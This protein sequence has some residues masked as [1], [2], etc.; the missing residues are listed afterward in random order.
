MKKT[1]VIAEAGINHNG[2]ISLAHH[3]IDVAADAGADV[4]KFQ[5]FRAESLATKNAPKAEYQISATTN[6]ESQYAMLN[7]LELTQ[8]AHE[9]LFEHCKKRGIKFLST[10][11]DLESLD[12]L[13]GFDMPF[14]KIPSGE[15]T[16]LPYLRKV[17]ALGKEIVLSTGMCELSEIQDA[18]H[19]LESA[20]T[21][22]EKVT[23]MHCTTDY[24]TS[25]ADVNL[26]AMLQ[27]Q[28]A[29]RVRVGYSDH[30]LGGITPIAAVAMGATMIEKHFTVDRSLPG[31]DHQASLTPTELRHMV[32]AIRNTEVLMGSPLKRP[33]TQEK[34]S[35]KIVRKSIVAKKEISE[36]ELFSE[37]NITSK[38]P[39]TGLS[40]M[41]WDSI[42]GTRAKRRFTADELIEL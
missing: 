15:I 3:L 6:G 16:N 19:Y 30:T 25:L 4:V 7:R 8:S 29:C 9:L 40:P 24:P 13:V 5:T 10:A 34:Q 33:T 22:R 37:E 18:L 38:R 23:V 26:R 42:I 35:M 41:L 20:G 31:P 2:D 11:F 17:G 27:I 39:G 12:L 1:V 32:D 21:P 14:Y 36:G 28:H